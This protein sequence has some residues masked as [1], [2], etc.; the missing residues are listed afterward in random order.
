[1]PETLLYL[2]APTPFGLGHALAEE[3]KEIG[4]EGGHPG[5]AGVSWRGSLEQAYRVLLWSRLASRVLMQLGRFPAPDGDAL[6]AGA[7]ELDWVSN[8]DPELTLA[9][10]TSVN[11]AAIHHSGFAAKRLKDAVVDTVRDAL[12]VRPSVDLREPDL[13]LHLHLQG[14][15]AT[16]SVDLAGDSLHR[17]GYRHPGAQAPLKE[18]LAAALLRLLGWPDI[19]KEGGAFVDPM[20]GS[21][22][23]PLE[24]AW[25]AGDRAP[26]LGSRRWGFLGWPGHQ[27]ELWALLIEE[28]KERAR[29]G[30]AK[31]PP[32]IGYD[33]ERAS[34]A[35]AISSARR[36]GLEGLIHLERREV[37][38]CEAPARS[39]DRPGLVAVNPPYGERLGT[40]SQLGP[41]YAG[42]ADLL[43]SAFSGWRAGVITTPDLVPRLGIRPGR[44]IPVRNGAIDCELVSWRVGISKSARTEVTA[45]LSD[46]LPLLDPANAPPGAEHFAARLRKRAKHISKWARRQDVSC[47]RIY[48]AD[49]TDYNVA[50]DRYGDHVQVQE[51]APP[52][53]VD[54]ELAARRLAV[55]MAAV[56]EVLSVDP[57]RV[58]LK[59]R[60]RHARGEQYE[61]MGEGGAFFEVR[62][63]K[64][65]FLVN[66]TDYLDTG[67]YLDH[68]PVRAMLGERALEKRLLNL[69][70]YTG[71]ATVH[72]ARGG[73]ASSVTVD[74]SN[75]YLGWARRNFTLN[76]LSA[77][78][79]EL[80]QADVLP[81]LKE[82]H[83][84]WDLIYVDPPTFSNSKDADTDFDIQR[85]QLELLGLCMDRLAPGGQVIFS[86]HGRR[87]KLDRAALERR[88]LKVQDL[89]RQTIPEDFKRSPRIHQV[90]MIEAS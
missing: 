88:G 1:M 81:W 67:L 36:A 63:G 30:L 77:R 23:L 24:A 71:T 69:Y 15:M 29:V 70:G 52:A 76:N 12:G 8:A 86:T 22:T 82:Q 34:V 53:H 74:R 5:A 13:T 11:N 32:I 44:R 3:L 65:A 78:K 60:R 75:T 17:R 7:R 19:A 14:S 46:G 47:Y 50:V 68:R 59:T 79:H 56:P 37:G 80:V 31:L 45:D 38:R 27:P 61:R 10:R 73:A 26:G 72:A 2:Y 54:P 83:N 89:S 21:G 43:A 85:D 28:A 16:V 20:C 51:Y 66:L 55:V 49:L 25:M 6:Y 18:N 57:E 41:L 64:C 4:V 87:F 48:D 84:K 40:A 58:H 39:G 62:E 33:G 90:Y 9:V 42:L 35:E